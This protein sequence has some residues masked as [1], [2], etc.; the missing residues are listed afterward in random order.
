MKVKTKAQVRPEAGADAER[1]S[2]SSGEQ[3]SCSRRSFL[4][5]SAVVAG[6]ATAVVG[7]GDDAT[8]AS[9]TGSRYSDHSDFQRPGRKLGTRGETG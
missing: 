5:S 4:R 1:E 9:I 8:G 3:K 7:A 2:S 6:A